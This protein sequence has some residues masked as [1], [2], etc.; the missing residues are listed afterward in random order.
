LIVRRYRLLIGAGVSLLLLFL[1]VR[2]IEV[3]KLAL[4]LR[5]AD[6]SYLLL[7]NLIRLGAF[8]LRA[9]RWKYLLRPVKDL[10]ARILL[11]RILIGYFGNYFLP[12]Q[13]G[14]LLRAFALARGESL[15]TSAVLATIIVER[16]LDVLILLFG[17]LV[18]LCLFPLPDWIMY[19][20]GLAS[21]LFAIGLLLLAGWHYREKDITH[22]LTTGLAKISS[23]LASKVKNLLASFSRGMLILREGRGM[24]LSA[25]LSFSAW[26]LM[27]VT[28]VLT[29]ASLGIS[30]AGYGYILLL[31]IFNLASLVPAL[32]GKV[33]TLEF[34][35]AGILAAFSADRSDALAFAVLFRATHIL[36]L[37]LGYFYLWREGFDLIEHA[38]ASQKAAV[39]G[40]S[41]TREVD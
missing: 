16:M 37:T 10:R 20:G 5:G 41:L 33:G 38:R 34:V 25:V 19:V 30:L 32:P 36:P 17:L 26:S 40:S 28:F 12:A 21:F 8:G 27:M 18:L 24:T 39:K 11:P 9:A 3:G 4:A 15:Q 2:S 35:F 31:V 13:S 23:S 29:G 7:A 22:L 1:V 14:E 6:Y